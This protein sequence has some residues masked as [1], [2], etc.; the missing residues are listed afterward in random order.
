MGPNGEARYPYKENPASHPSGVGAFQ[1][2]D[3][4]LMSNLEA[5]AMHNNLTDKSPSWGETCYSTTPDHS[6]FFKEDGEWRGVI[7]GQFAQWY[8]GILMGHVDQVLGAA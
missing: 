3:D 6:H 2:F 1:C 4:Y 8:S 5:Y 7:E